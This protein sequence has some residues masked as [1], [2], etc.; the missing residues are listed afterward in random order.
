MTPKMLADAARA[1]GS[2]RVSTATPV[3]IFLLLIDRCLLDLDG[4]ARAR[5]GGDL[6]RARTL[7]G[8]AR[9]IL[10]ELVAGL[11]RGRGGELAERLVSLYVFALAR[12][13]TTS[14]ASD[15][16]EARTV[17]EP[18]A[19]AYHQIRAGVSFAR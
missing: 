13:K 1:Y 9:D 8:H 6:P 18:I 16:R 3:D 15:L 10:F 2:A 17:L 5:E 11:D 7:A 19:Q 12:T 4:A 14:P